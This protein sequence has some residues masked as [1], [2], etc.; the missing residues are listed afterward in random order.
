MW[1]RPSACA[2]LPAPPPGPPFG[3]LTAYSILE[4][5]RDRAACEPILNTAKTL[6]PIRKM[7]PC[8]LGLKL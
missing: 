2:G 8:F 4:V 7:G 5:A 6:L 3:Y 1:G